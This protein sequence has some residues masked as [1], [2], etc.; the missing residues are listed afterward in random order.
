VLR[1]ARVVA[2]IAEA[3]LWPILVLAAAVVLILA[4][5]GLARVAPADTLTVAELCSAAAGLTALFVAV[6]IGRAVVALNAE[7]V[8]PKIRHFVALWLAAEVDLLVQRGGRQPDMLAE[9]YVVVVP[10]DDRVE[11]HIALSFKECLSLKG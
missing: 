7:V 11:L 4:A 2:L 8:E 10:E 9:L 3:L 6:R 1:A 5:R